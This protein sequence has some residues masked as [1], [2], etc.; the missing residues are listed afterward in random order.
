MLGENASFSGHNR[1]K[2]FHLK[3]ESKSSSDE[4]RRHAE[5]GAKQFNLL[6]DHAALQEPALTLTLS[7]PGVC[8]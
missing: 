4:Q 6:A 1:T 5:A 8:T 3:S 2:K 7:V